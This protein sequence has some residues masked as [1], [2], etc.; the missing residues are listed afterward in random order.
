MNK[1]FFKPGSVPGNDP[2]T[3]ELRKTEVEGSAH[4]VNIT[5]GGEFLDDGI[6]MKDQPFPDSD[7]PDNT[8]FFTDYE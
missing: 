3:T 6:R 1:L 4:E 2:G 7:T 5:D 8:E